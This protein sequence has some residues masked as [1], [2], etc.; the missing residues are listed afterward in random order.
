MNIVLTGANGFLGKI[1]RKHLE[2][3]DCVLHCLTRDNINLL[4]KDEVESYFFEN[5]IDVVFHTAITGGRRTKK[6]SEVDFY[7]NIKMFEILDSAAFNAKALFN[8]A[9]GAEYDRSRDIFFAQEKDLGY[10]VPLD[11][12]GLSKYIISKQALS[13]KNKWINLRIF[14][15]FGITEENDRMIKS[16]ISRKLAGEEI[17]VHQN[18][19]MDFFHQ[20]DMLKVIDFYLDNINKLDKL[21]N[22]VNL[23]YGRHSPCQTLYSIAEYIDSLEDP[24][25]GISVKDIGY[26][27]SYC[28]SGKRLEKMKINLNGIKKS[29]RLV[30]N[31]LKKM[32]DDVKSMSEEHNVK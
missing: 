20:T 22:D 6:D 32:Q 26:S 27:K 31:D 5:D 4:N 30:Y 24:K 13:S 7:N 11:F 19:Y 25:V 9:S 8:F 12:Y 16:A 2:K 23:S 18:K 28:G 15:C 29:I 21:P 10:K 17:I 14:N 3:E 1:L